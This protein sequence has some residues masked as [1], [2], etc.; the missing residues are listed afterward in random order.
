MA[1][2]PVQSSN[3][4]WVDHDV[5]RN[6]MRVGFKTGVVYEYD[7]ISPELFHTVVNADSVGKAVRQ[8][9]NGY[10]YRRIV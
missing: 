3:V 2:I 7:G 8:I 1:A 9:A 10:V 4:S 5:E 6:V